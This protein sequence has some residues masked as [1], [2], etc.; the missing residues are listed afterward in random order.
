MTNARYPHNLPTTDGQSEILDRI[1]DWAN[2]DDNIRAIVLNGSMTRQAGAT[3]RFSDLD[4]QIIATDRAPLIADDTWLTDIAPVWV[5]EYLGNG[6]DFDSR[7]VFYEGARKVDFT[8]ND[9][10][11]IDQMSAIQELDFL[12]RH[13]YAV[14]MDKDGLT[15]RLPAVT[16]EIPI[17]ALPTAD[18]FRLAV[19]L[20]WFEAAH[21]PTYLQRNELWVVKFRDWT[22]KSSLLQLLEWHA[23]VVQQRQVN[24]WY[25]GTKMEHWLDRETW[26]EL[27]GVFGHFDPAD[28]W[29]SLL[30]MIDLFV[31]ITHE[32]A[33]QLGYP[34]PASEH[35][36]RNY[37]LG[38]AP[39]A[40]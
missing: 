32:I 24:V 18:E 13:G 9:R 1:L 8:I 14:L 40:Q 27:H 33:R 4:V 15:D 37:I 12:Y 29:R 31:R 38:F 35:H 2:R 20:F 28:C 39:P 30:N 10:R 3:D 34:V 17:A 11:Q 6:D 16:P 21:M 26:E 25:I 22:M 36:I 23:A 19:D 5:A 7:L